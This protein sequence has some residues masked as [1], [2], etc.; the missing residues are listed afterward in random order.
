MLKKLIWLLLIGYNFPTLYAQTV[1]YHPQ[2]QK[3][4]PIAE[5]AGAMKTEKRIIVF[6]FG[7]RKRYVKHCGIC[8]KTVVDFIL[9]L[10]QMLPTSL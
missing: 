8:L 7:L 5:E 3:D 4:M 1:W 10:Q 2:E 9:T 6:P